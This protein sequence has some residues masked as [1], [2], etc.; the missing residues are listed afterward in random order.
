MS[1]GRAAGVGAAVAVVALLG[2]RGAAAEPQWN[3]A[4]VAGAAGVGDDDGWWRRTATYAAVRGELLL[5]RARNVELGGGPYV[6]VGSVAWE[7]VR[8]GAGASWL[9]P[10]NEYVPVVLSGGG[11]ARFGG[12][13]AGA[14]VAGSVFIGAHSHNFHSAY[15]MVWGLVV[16]VERSVAGPEERIVTVAAHLD[17][18]G[19]AL[20]GLF[21][22]EAVKGPPHEE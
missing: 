6:S 8:P 14:G 18:L 12:A 19:L 3:G 4:L 16:G 13:R 15:A 10:L 5:G 11:Y 22:Y 7:D 21:L 20:P 17:L 2:A 1:G 9:V